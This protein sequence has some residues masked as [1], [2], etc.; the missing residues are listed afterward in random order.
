[1]YNTIRK[2]FILE[3]PGQT[4]RLKESQRQKKNFAK[5]NDS[6]SSTQSHIRGMLKMP[7]IT[8]MVAE[9]ISA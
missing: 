7:M 5:S 8:T 2:K 3:N 1:M 9:L 4:V 6:L